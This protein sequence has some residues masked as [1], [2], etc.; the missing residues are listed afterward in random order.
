MSGREIVEIPAKNVNSTETPKRQLR[1]A[2]YCRVSTNQEAQQNSFNRQQ[3]YYTEKI[4]ANP[5]WTLVGIFADE[6]ITGTSADKRPGFQKMIRWCQKGK[7][8]YIITKSVSRFSR[9]TLECIYYVRLL[10]ELGIPILFESEGLNTSRMD[11]E[12]ILTILGATSQAESEA[13]SQRIKWGVRAGFKQGNVRYSY[14]TWLGY[15]K[16]EDGKP[17]I[18]P[19]EA[20]V[21]R[22]IF[23]AYLDGES[24]RSI[25]ER[26][27]REGIPAKNEDEKWTVQIVQNILNNEK[28]TGDVLL[29]KTYTTDP[30]TKRKKKNKGELPQYLVKN[31]HDAIISHEIFDLVQEENAK[32]RASVQIN[33]EKSNN[34]CYSGKY[35]LS[36]ILVCGECNTLYRRCTWMSNG[37][38]H[39][40]W[41]CR[42][43]LENGKK[44]CKQSPTL[45]EK[46]LHSALVKAINK[47]LYRPE[48]LLAPFEK[49]ELSSD[50]DFDLKPAENMFELYTELVVKNN[51]ID[52]A[53]IER[54]MRFAD[55]QTWDGNTEFFENAMA[56]QREYQMYIDTL[57]LEKYEEERR[58]ITYS[59]PFELTQYND[60]IVR[61]VIDTVK[62]LD[63][64]RLQV[65]FKGGITEEQ[66]IE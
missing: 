35:A 16:G 65:I 8:D 46:A 17:E 13:T 61:H 45:D 10:Q 15:R 51:K 38:R 63:K 55:N 11:N 62:V 49:R 30:I 34:K 26:L 60:V 52:D 1:V 39:I 19:K 32:R 25:T 59:I 40:V 58:K 5:D 28:Y 3:E 21:V 50:C 4:A 47:Q 27:T 24:L 66:T 37:K 2:A 64:N 57:H 36:E 48:Y 53:V 33:N 56:K 12:L 20:E 6:G 18:V 22:K 14:K 9:N 43:R 54:I 31:C 29:Q 7:I 44:Y 41:R 23:K 42:N